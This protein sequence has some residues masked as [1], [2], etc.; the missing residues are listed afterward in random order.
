MSKNKGMLVF[1]CLL[2]VLAIFLIALG[3]YIKTF[4]KKVSTVYY[5]EQSDKVLSNPYMGFVPAATSKN[6][7]QPF[8]MV[9]AGVSWKEL[10]PEKGNYKFDE[11]EKKIKF[12]Y[13]KDRNV[14][15]V[16]R[17]YMDYP[18]KEKAMDI[19]EWLYEEIGK[20]GIW[21][22]EGDH[23]GFSPDYGNKALIDNHEKI[24]KAIAERYDKDNAV[25]FIQLGS[26]GHYG[27]WHTAYISRE[28]K[29]FPE[30]SLSDIY[31]KHYINSFKD[32]KLLMR[33]PF[34]I[35]RDNN[36]GLFNDSFG[37]KKQTEDYFLTWINNGYKDHHFDYYHPDMKD[38][39]KSAPSSGEFSNYPGEIWISEGNFEKTLAMLKESH[40]S[41]LGPSAPIYEEL[42]PEKQIKIDMILKTMGYRFKV[43]Q[44]TYY[45]ELKSG[46]K[47]EGIIRISNEG[48]APFYFDWPMY[49]TFRDS[50]VVEVAKLK[51]DYD[52]R[53]LLPG[54]A[55]IKYNINLR[56]DL[57]SGEYKIYLFIADTEGG[58]P[59]I[60][61]ANETLSEDK[62]CY[63]GSFKIEN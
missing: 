14:K 34:K 35:A 49:V 24:I 62:R 33:R 50:K 30:V 37:D 6:V 51:L 18:S 44:S 26:L 13:W 57:E 32:K 48:I 59:A 11:F 21:Y 45:A 29:A 17:F 3:I 10:E 16:I 31:V 60:E 2:T 43:E 4:N 54:E 25:A 38:F 1:L 8:S 15:F 12:Q 28:L 5:P 61:F 36:M 47:Q 41:F 55:E 46:D 56:S 7:Y 58:N 42:T 52:I 19:P 9:Y 39:W 23:K 40:T 20:N 27:E 53:T 22:E 63:L